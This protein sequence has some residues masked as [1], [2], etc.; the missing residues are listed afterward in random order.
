MTCSSSGSS[1]AICGHLTCQSKNL[2]SDNMQASYLLLLQM[3]T[4]TCTP[5]HWAA[6]PRPTGTPALWS[7]WAHCWEAAASDPDIRATLTR[8]GQNSGNEGRYCI[9][10]AFRFSITL[11]VIIFVDYE[12]KVGDSEQYIIVYSNLYLFQSPVIRNWVT[13]YRDVSSKIRQREREVWGEA[14]VGFGRDTEH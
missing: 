9:Q 3:L 14:W 12:C 5:D 1:I 8:G 7:Y 6:Y 11:V 2:T 13:H 10:K 4:W